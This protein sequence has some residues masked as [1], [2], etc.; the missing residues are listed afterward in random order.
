MKVT[1]KVQIGKIICYEI[2]FEVG[3]KECTGELCENYNAEG[4]VSFYTFDLTD[5]PEELVNTFTT[6]FLEEIKQAAYKFTK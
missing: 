6:T 1:S 4:T 2:L 3:G 5:Y